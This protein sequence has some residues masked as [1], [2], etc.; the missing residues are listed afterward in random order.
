M[1]PEVRNIVVACDTVKRISISVLLNLGFIWGLKLLGA[2]IF[3]NFDTPIYG[4]FPVSPYTK[5]L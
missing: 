3:D 4:N 1:T 5:N 2:D